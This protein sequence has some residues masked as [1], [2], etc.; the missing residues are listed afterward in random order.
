VI[1]GVSNQFLKWEQPGNYHYDYIVFNSTNY[2][3][4]SSA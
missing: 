1:S 4:P 2:M 3:D